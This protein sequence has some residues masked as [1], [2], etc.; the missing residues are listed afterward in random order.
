M[1]VAK[2]HYDT[3][4]KMVEESVGQTIQQ[5]SDFSLLRDKINER[6]NESLSVSTLKRFWGYVRSYDTVRVSTLNI[7]SR[8]VGF[9]SWDDF[10][11]YAEKGGEASDF[12]LGQ[13][14]K[15]RDLAVGDVVTVV[16]PPDRRCSFRRTGE[17][18]VVDL[19]ENSR[20]KK[21]DTFKCDTFIIGE[22]CYLYD[23]TH[24]GKSGQT[25]VIGKNTGLT[26][27]RRGK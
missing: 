10:V 19:S 13:S 12:V 15:A 2:Q 11:E 22:P 4:K 7:L 25:Y 16:Y 9:A 24:G 23:L 17:G 14:L 26:D 20:L 3:L 27:V 8:F 21:G 5:P 6:C 18:Y 1:T